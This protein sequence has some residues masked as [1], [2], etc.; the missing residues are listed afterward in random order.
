MKLIY[1]T[2][3]PGMP[4]YNFYTNL[5]ITVNGVK[6]DTKVAATWAVPPKP[7]KS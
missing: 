2:T 5:H 3:F 7:T 1:S 6:V 4:I